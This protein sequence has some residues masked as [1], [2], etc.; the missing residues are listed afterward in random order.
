MG[1]ASTPCG[2]ATS[3]CKN[4][5]SESL[6]VESRRKSLQH[7]SGFSTITGTLCMDESTP[8][9]TLTKEGSEASVEMEL[10]ILKQRNK[11]LTE[12]MHKLMHFVEQVVGIPEALQQKVMGEMEGSQYT[13]SNI[14]L[15]GLA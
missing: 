9:P 3:S 6:A 10:E 13:A 1:T 14:D 8:E 5:L 11:G 2:F 4:S 12:D 15:E 7:V